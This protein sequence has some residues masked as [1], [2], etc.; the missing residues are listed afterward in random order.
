[1]A[2]A[3]AIIDIDVTG[4]DK[5]K[6]LRLR[7]KEVEKTFKVDFHAAIRAA[8]EPLKEEVRQS[9]LST[10]PKRGGL[11]AKV[12][13]ST[14]AVRNKPSS[15]TFETT[16]PYAIKRIDQGTVRHPVFGNRKAWVIE[17]VEPGFWSKA[18]LDKGPKIEAEVTAV[19]EETIRKI[20]G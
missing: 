19:V 4:R 3:E 5:L 9:A 18:V 12:A 7:L 8:V 11:A 1:M 10:L 17:K 14:F 6:A 20:D 16:N 2:D 13:A 15:V